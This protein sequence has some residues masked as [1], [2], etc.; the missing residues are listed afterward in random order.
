MEAGTLNARPPHRQVRDSEAEA[1]EEE[2]QDVEG[3]LVVEA[4][5]VGS[6]REGMGN[7]EALAVHS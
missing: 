1:V 3:S 5:A 4:A 2:L 6:L 7:W